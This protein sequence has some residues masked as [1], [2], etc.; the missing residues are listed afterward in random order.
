MDKKKILIV[1]KSFYPRIAPRSFRASELAKEFARQGHDVT[2]LTHK[3]NYDY[4]NFENTNNIKIEDFVNGKWKEIKGNNLCFEGFRLIFKYLF[5]YP[6]IQ[7]TPLLKKSLKK[8]NSFDLL[9]SI[10]DPY[11]VHWGVALGKKKNPTLCKCWVADCGD[12]FMGNKEKRL[13]HPFYFHFVEKWFCKK[14]DYITIPIEKASIAYPEICRNK[15]RIIPQGFNFE[16]NSNKL[17][18]SKNNTTTLFAYAGTLCKGYRDPSEFL[19][20]LSTQ[21]NKDFKF[22]VYT[23]SLPVIKPY[24][25]KL[26][27]KIEVREYI[28]REQLL[29]ELNT[30]DFL[31]NIENQNNVQSP[32]KLIDYAI[33]GKP[34]ISIKPFHLN[35]QVIDEFLDGNYTNQYIIEN[36]DQYNI[37][38]VTNEFL[39]LTQL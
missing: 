9:V 21:K 36:I 32:S 23:R 5:L 3:K 29:E 13:K 31:V 34:V 24:I 39:K 37:K 19:E 26:G 7:S 16:A 14:P 20:Y 15:I 12:P 30:M 38:N 10:A 27:E 17:N 2:V 6:E 4:T 35:P 11:P 1:S 22:I 28:P 8:F 33:V 18:T 25:N